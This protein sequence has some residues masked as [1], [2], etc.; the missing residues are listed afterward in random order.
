MCNASTVV[1]YIWSQDKLFYVPLCSCV[2]LYDISTFISTAF[3]ETLTKRC[4]RIHEVYF[5]DT[6]LLSALYI[7]YCCL[8]KETPNKNIIFNHLQRIQCFFFLALFDVV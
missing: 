2:H 8:L 3:Y 7:R 1:S 5:A 4:G 6:F